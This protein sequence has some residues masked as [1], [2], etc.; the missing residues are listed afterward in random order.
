LL[1]AW[2]VDFAYTQ[3]NLVPTPSDYFRQFPEQCPGWLADYNAGDA[4][5]RDDFFGS[6]IGFYPGAGNDGHI[7]RLLGSTHSTHCFVYVDYGVTQETHEAEMQHAVRGFRGYHSLAQLQLQQND[8]VPHGW[9]PHI[10][11][12]DLPQGGAHKIP[13][14]VQPYGFL[15]ILERDQDLTDEHG[16]HR[17]AILFLGADGIASYDALFCQANATSPFAALIQDHGFGGNYN[18]FG[19]NGLLE[20][21]AVRANIFPEYLI[22]ADGTTPWEGYALVPDLDGERGGQHQMLRRLYKRQ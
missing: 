6:R 16:A 13:A 9:A 12:H 20:R 22:V 14:T 3:E 5:S 17:L 7:V 10:Q 1:P 2:S 11:D 8:L 18:H 21:V 15:Q 4:F 19:R